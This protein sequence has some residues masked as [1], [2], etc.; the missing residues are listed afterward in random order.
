M[1]T[2]TSTE[3][4]F[5]RWGSQASDHRGALS[6]SQRLS[7]AQL[8]PEESTV[9]A[10]QKETESISSSFQMITNRLGQLPRANEAKVRVLKPPH[11]MLLADTNSAS[12][13]QT[14]SESWLHTGTKPRP[15]CPPESQQPLTDTHL[16][17]LQGPTGGC[18]VAY[19]PI[20]PFINS[21]LHSFICSAN[22]TRDNTRHLVRHGSADNLG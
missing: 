4:G 14:N 7:M 22:L 1:A 8:Q 2:F 3:T 15:R 11:P 17:W 19:F 18:R 21:S 20:A 16:W 12:H 9:R 10:H 5:H 6:S 13:P